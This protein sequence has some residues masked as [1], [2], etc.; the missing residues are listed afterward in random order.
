MPRC[1]QRTD[2]LG[3]GPDNP[4]NPPVGGDPGQIILLDRPQRFGRRGIA[5]KNNEMAS[6]SEKPLDS[7]ERIGMDAFKRTVSIRSPCIIPQ[8]KEVIHGQE[9][10][11]LPQ[12]GQAAE[13]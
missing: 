2:T 9:P 1:R 12:H 8:I 11:D 6:L 13:A 5:G 7:F 4:Q 3:D 10:F